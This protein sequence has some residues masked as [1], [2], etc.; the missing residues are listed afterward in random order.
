MLQEEH[1]IVYVC[2]VCLHC[3]TEPGIH[4]SRPMLQCDA[5]CPGDE[6]SKPIESADGR[7]LTRAPRWW[8]FRQRTRI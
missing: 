5:G 4:H 8:I 7:L 3:S 2:E 6:C 1:R